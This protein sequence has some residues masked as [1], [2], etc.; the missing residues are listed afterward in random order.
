ML[1]RQVA[2]LSK[3]KKVS[4]QELMRVSAALQRQA[5]RDLAPIWSIQATV[6]SF[7]SD[8]DVPPGYWKITVMDKI[9]AKGAAGFHLDKNGQPFADV[10]WSSN[11]S[12]SASHE[13]LEMLVDPFGHQL[14]SGPS[15]I[16][17]QGRVN[18]L[19]EVCDPC[20]SPS[21]A[22]TINTATSVEVLVSDFYTPDFFAPATV[23]GVRY[24]FRGNLQAPRQVLDGGYLSWQNP[25]DGHVW[26]L[27]GP[28]AMQHFVDQGQGSLSRENSDRH[29]HTTRTRPVAPKSAKPVKSR[30]ILMAAGGQCNLTR[31]VF[32]GV[33][34]GNAGDQT[35]VQIKDSTGAAVFQSISYA[36]SQIGSNTASATFTIKAG[37]N[38]LSFVYA[39]PVPGDGLTLVDPCG[40]R[41]DQFPNDLA[42]PVRLRQVVA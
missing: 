21:C 3:T 25:A 33:L 2:L 13:C 14:A 42:N 17:S 5:T 22:Y 23:P 38:D 1:T 36:G 15:P 18:F 16:S 9:P 26:Q 40:T 20:E 41:L 12:L 30:K 7:S 31:D 35:T 39:A 6:D 24:S 19:V 27:F 8:A 37:S 32:T 10:E 28:A 11:W 34:R 29:A 4:A